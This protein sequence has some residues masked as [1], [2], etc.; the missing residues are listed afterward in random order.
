[1]KHFTE[2]ILCQQVN[3]QAYLMQ[4]TQRASFIV[5]TLNGSELFKFQVKCEIFKG[6]KWFEAS[7]VVILLLETALLFSWHFIPDY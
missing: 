5:L 1:M 4:A 3:C 7:L 2:F 6:Y